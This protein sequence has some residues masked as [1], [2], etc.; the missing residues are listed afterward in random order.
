MK[1]TL[2]VVFKIDTCSIIKVW[3][4][5]LSGLSEANLLE[6]YFRINGNVL[7]PPNKVMGYLLESKSKHIGVTSERFNLSVGDVGAHNIT[8]L[9]ITG[10]NIDLNVIA[11][12]LIELNA[13]QQAFI[14]DYDFDYWQNAE[15]ILQYKA[16]GKVYE[17][18][19]LI[20]NRL[21]F[22][23]EQKIIDT[24]KNPGK[25]E[26]KDG[27]IKVAAYRMWLDANLVERLG[28]DIKSLEMTLGAKVSCH[29]DIYLVHVGESPFTESTPKEVLLNMKNL[30]FRDIT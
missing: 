24:T 27:Y 20:S 2:T 13:I 22:P 19:P 3:E 23:L 28:V 4:S 12:K 30:I 17:H 16:K 9:D 5:A 26:I 10:K 25:Y 29:N 1:L 8:R 7:L 6:D 21:P 14:V 15:D 11:N 18:L